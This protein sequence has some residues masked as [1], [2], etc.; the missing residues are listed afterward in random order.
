MFSSKF[1]P[2][3]DEY[4]VGNSEDELERDNHFDLDPDDDDTTSRALVR[5][6]TPQNDQAF[7]G[8]LQQVTRIQGLSSRVLKHENFHFTIQDI[9]TVTAG[10]QNTR[11][12]PLEF[13]N[14]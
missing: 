7:E 6:F 9:K 5:V 12:S 3:I 11:F 14:D 8:E 1:L 10:R 13:P 4:E 2:L